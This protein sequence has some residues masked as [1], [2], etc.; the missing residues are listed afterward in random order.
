MG[1]PVPGPFKVEKRTM[2]F[3]ISPI[4]DAS[5][6]S[7]IHICLTGPDM[8]DFSSVLHLTITL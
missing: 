5:A 2:C 4:T 6:P 3:Q 1:Q 8:S 7:F